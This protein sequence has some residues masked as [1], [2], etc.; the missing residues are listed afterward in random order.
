MKRTLSLVLS[1][2]MILGIFT[3]MP[4]TVNAATSTDIVESFSIDKTL[5]SEGE[6]AT[7]T[8]K[9]AEGYTAKWF[10]FYKPITNN[11]VTVYLNLVSDNTYTGTFT[12]DDQ[13][14]AGIWKVKN[15]TFKNSSGNWEYLYNSDNYTSTYYDKID[16]STLNFEVVGTDADVTPPVLESYSRN[17]NTVSNGENITFTAKVIDE[18]LPTSFYLY[19]KSPSNE[20]EAISMK[21]IDNT[22]LYQGAFTINSETEIGLWKPYYFSISDTNANTFSL[23]NSKLNSYGSNKADLSSLNFEVVE[24][25]NGSNENGES[26]IIIFKDG[27]GNTLSTQRVAKGESAIAPDAPT[28]ELYLFNGWDT[29]FS[30]V[31]SNLIVTATWVVDPNAVYDYEIHQG[32]SFNI[33]VFSQASQDYTITCNEDINYTKSLYGTSYTITNG[34]A[35]YGKEYKITVNDPGSYF[36]YVKGS[37]ASN[38]LDYKVKVNPHKYKTETISPTCIAQGY[39]KYTCTICKSTYHSNYVEKTAHTWKNDYVID[40]VGNCVTDEIKS[41]HCSYCDCIKEGS[42]IITSATGQHTESGWIVDVEATCTEN[43]SKHKECTVCNKTIETVAIPIIDHTIGD[44]ITD[45]QPTTTTTGSKHKECTVCGKVIETATIAKIPVTPSTK[46]TSTFNG[47]QIS[48]N[49]VAGATKY[50]VYRRNAGSS[51]W[52]AIGTTTSTSLVDKNVTA[53]KY[54]IYSVRAYNAEGSYSAYIGAK[55]KTI[56]YILTPTAVATNLTNGVQ[57]KWNS[58]VGATKYNVYRRVGG[59]SSWVLVGT[60]TNTS[61]VDKNVVYGK[62]Y[63]YSIRAINGTGYSVFDTKK[64]DT[65]QPI[66]A[67]T[68]KLQNRADGVHVSWNKVDGATKYNVYRRLGGTSTWVYVGSTTGTGGLDKGAVKGKSYAYSIRAI[69]GTGYSAYDSSKCASIKHT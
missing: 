3:S 48:W 60:T 13:T 40:I 42:Q 35:Y 5:L 26:F 25:N 53:G 47:I 21:K 49:T 12:V 15:L 8:I 68:A 29:D 52:N 39:T 65:I 34:A 67:P 37:R 69:N 24:I 9:V 22:G 16:F 1:L 57:I 54:Y 20:S 7:I 2:I 56:Q 14:E 18:H 28:N 63:V 6:S 4:V 66:T 62:Y 32:G 51:A 64:T 50:V 11:T 38:T 36:F 33:E 23:Y 41:I 44:W 46:A 45:T 61:L 59:S 19:Y 17:K 27:Y 43:G 10:Y 31:T 30:N 58:V 55:T